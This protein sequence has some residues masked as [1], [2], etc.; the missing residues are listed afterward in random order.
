MPTRSN[1]DKE[2][3]IRDPIYGFVLLDSQEMEIVNSIYFQRLRRIKQLSLTDMIYPGACHTRFEHSL[4]VMQMASDMFDNIVRNNSNREKL[5]L[6][7][8]AIERTRKIVRMAALLHDV[9]HAPFSHSG[10]ESMP[11]ITSTHKKNQTN[12]SKRY[13]HE[14]YSIASIKFLFKDLIEHHPLSDNL[15]IRVE[16]VT[17][18]LGDQTVPPTRTSIVW[19][20]LISG[21][22]DADRSDYL[23]RD[24]L[25][26]GVSYGTF[27]RSRLINCIT[28]GDSDEQSC[29]LA[30]E[31]GGLHVAESIVIARY[32]M[33]SQVYFHPV[34]RAFDYHVGEAIKETLGNLNFKDCL[35][36]R[37]TTESNIKKYLNIDDWKIYSAIKERKA[38]KHGEIILNRKHYKCKMEWNRYP[39]KDE[40]QNAT[41]AIKKY[42]GHLDLRAETKWYKLEKDIMIVNKKSGKSY[43]LSY[44]SK[45]IEVMPGLPKMTRL[46]INCEGEGADYEFVTM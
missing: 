37:P 32:Q 3:K 17:S 34:R 11:F 23:L 12:K 26:I 9:G 39:N 38:G 46:Y 8:A 1:I 10:E 16:D 20:E 7:D 44:K 2:Y 30:I 28:I 15:G 24:S 36:P 22:L 29:F 25:H 6:K 35:F 4:G 40:M 21:Q 42:E 43:P 33:F 41:E 13:G 19:K 14:D 18:L 5:F 31:E 45:L 27:D